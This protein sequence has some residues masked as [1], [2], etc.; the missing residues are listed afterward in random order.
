MDSVFGFDYCV[1]NLTLN[2]WKN[3]L[4]DEVLEKAYNMVFPLIKTEN[5]TNKQVRSEFFNYMVPRM[6]GFDS[7]CKNRN[8]NDKYVVQVLELYIRLKYNLNSKHYIV[9]VD[10]DYLFFEMENTRRNVRKLVKFNKSI[11]C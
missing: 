8:L 6:Y 2:D 3:K 1:K 5:K 4:D 10:N 11:I 9:N 7:F